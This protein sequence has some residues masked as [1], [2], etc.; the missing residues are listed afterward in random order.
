MSGPGRL[1]PSCRH[2]AS[3]LLHSLSSFRDHGR[4]CRRSR[5]GPGDAVAGSD[6]GW[7][8]GAGLWSRAYLWITTRCAVVLSVIVSA[9]PQSG[10][11][12]SLT[13]AELGARGEH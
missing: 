5:L 3:E 2:S 7:V 4:S 1:A 6:D 9:G 10:A 13:R 12:T 8:G 11:M